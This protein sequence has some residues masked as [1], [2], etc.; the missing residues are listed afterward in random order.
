M[1]KEEGKK[2]SVF[3]SMPFLGNDPPPNLGRGGRWRA[4]C[5]F[6]NPSEVF[7]ISTQAPSLPGFC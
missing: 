7:C 1:E 6:P 2:P 4:V 5:S 3:C